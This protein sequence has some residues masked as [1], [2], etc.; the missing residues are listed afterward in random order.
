MSSKPD[1]WDIKFVSLDILKEKIKWY[2]DKWYNS[3]WFLWWDIS[4]HPDL[5]EIVAYSKKCNYLNINIISKWM[6][7]DDFELSN[8]LVKNWLTRI[9]FSIH[10]HLPEIE[11]YLIQVEWWLKR[12]MKAIDNF[13]ILYNK[14]LLRDNLSI[15][16]VINKKNYTTIIESILYFAFKKSVKDIRLNFIWLEEWVKENWD[17]LTLSYSDFLPYLKKI[18]YISIKYK[19]RITFDTVPACIFYK[20]DNK[21]YKN[22]IKKFLWED[23]DHIVEI[24]HINWNDTFDWKKRKKD[25]LK[26]QFDDCKKCIYRESCQWVRREYASIYWWD[27]FS[28]ILWKNNNIEKDMN[29]YYSELNKWNFKWVKNDIMSLYEKDNWEGNSNLYSIYLSKIKDFD[30]SNKV[31]LDLLENHKGIIELWNIYF[32]IS[33]NYLNIWN[34]KKTEEYLLKAEDH[35]WEN[36]NFKEFKKNFYSNNKKYNLDDYNEETIDYFKQNDKLTLEKYTYIN[37][38]IDNI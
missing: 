22:I 20:V 31:L 8:N 14:W 11:D 12:K 26:T 35:I 34:N 19:I 18:I 6:K 38:L 36:K 1:L 9:N 28:A 4:I 30:K 16:I 21:N 17:D 32:N 10:S 29:Y 7:F 24:D 5:V 27:E 2:S 37:K 15:N 25:K 3:I 13:N 23:H 33:V